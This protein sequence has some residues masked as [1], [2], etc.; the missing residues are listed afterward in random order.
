MRIAK[1]KAPLR[2]IA[3]GQGKPQRRLE[4]VAMGQEKNNRRVLDSQRFK[5]RIEQLQFAWLGQNPANL[6]TE[7]DCK[8]LYRLCTDDRMQDAWGLMVSLDERDFHG[9]IET[10]LLCVHGVKI[11]PK[12][13]ERYQEKHAMIANAL[14][15]TDAFMEICQLPL[16]KTVIQELL[17]VGSKEST[18][19][20][21]A[22]PALLSQ[23]EE[24]YDFIKRK[25]ALCA[26][27]EEEDSHGQ[28]R[29]FEGGRADTIRELA[30][31]I[32]GVTGKPHYN[33]VATLANVV[34]DTGDDDDITADA[35]RKAA[36]RKKG[37]FARIK[38]SE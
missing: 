16:G 20:A 12:M 13:R 1:R 4:V 10:M 22:F 35:V 14:S 7:E 36:S 8:L 6:G 29:K 33:V 3:P 19:I 11:R 37:L 26:R 2:I 38:N 32:K 21:E 5:A 9:L 27:H 25:A 18:T 24:V 23:M 31:L 28:S 30:D 17:G 34:L 15:I